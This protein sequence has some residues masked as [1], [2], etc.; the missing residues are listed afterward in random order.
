MGHLISPTLNLRVTLYDA[1]FQFTYFGSPTS[2][3]LC[4]QWGLQSVALA[5]TLW[6]PLQVVF[7]FSTL[8]LLYIHPLLWWTH[9]TSWLYLFYFICYFP[10][11]IFF[12]YYTAN[13]MALNGTSNLCLNCGL[14]LTPVPLIHFLDISTWIF[15]EIS[16]L[17]CPNGS[18]GTWP[19]SHL[20]SSPL[21]QMAPFHLFWT[22]MF[23]FILT[24]FPFLIYKLWGTPSRGFKNLSRAWPSPPTYIPEI[25][26][27]YSLYPPL[28]TSGYSPRPCQWSCLTTP[29]LYSNPNDF[30]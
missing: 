19:P 2:E 11:T 15:T 16:S 30:S 13:F 22:K 4:P 3:V 12:P 28:L 7:S 21:Q 23:G 5:L 20:D 24:S 6:N 14:L 10:N 8:F 1:F 26:P 29:I 27:N 17:T 9:P 18:L 25:A